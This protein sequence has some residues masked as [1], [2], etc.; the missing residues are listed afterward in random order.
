MSGCSF[1]VVEFF[2]ESLELALCLGLV[3]DLANSV[4][5]KADKGRNKQQVDSGTDGRYDHP[6]TRVLDVHEGEDWTDRHD[7]EALEQVLDVEAIVE[8]AFEELSNLG[9]A[10]RG[11]DWCFTLS[12][13][14]FNNKMQANNKK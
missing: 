8:R 6:C 13:N 4:Y 12:V 2:V 10:V 9:F 14:S 1:S 5:N 7:H 11:F 3:V